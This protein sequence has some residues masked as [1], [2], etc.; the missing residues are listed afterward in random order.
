MA[1][2]F[3]TVCS[4]YTWFF[5]VSRPNTLFAPFVCVCLSILFCDGGG[6]KAT[7]ERRVWALV[8]RL[9]FVSL[10]SGIRIMM[11]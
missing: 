4:K 1:L 8:H 2:S 3:W 10:C 6:L 11:V 7:A 5:I 9:F